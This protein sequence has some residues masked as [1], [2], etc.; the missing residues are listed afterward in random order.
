MEN[1]KTL[2]IS[3]TLMLTKHI[4]NKL[5]ECVITHFKTKHKIGEAYND[6]QLFG[7]GNFKEEKPNLKS[8]F[9]QILKGYVNGKYLYNKSREANSGKPIIKI[10]R[11]Y[12][13]VFFNYLGYKNIS[14]FLADINISSSQKE[15]QLDLVQQ[16]G[17]LEDF[18]YVCYYFGEDNQMNKGSVIIYNQWKTIE[19]KYLYE[20]E[21]GN[22]STYTFFGNITH[23]EDF[24]FFDTKYYLGNKKNEGAKFIFFI[25]KSSP[26]ERNY[27]AGTYSGF[28]KYHRAIAGKMILKKYATKLEVEEEVSNRVFDSIICLE[29]TK[30]RIIVESNI[31]KNPIMFSK[32]S[33]YAKVLSNTSG[34]YNAHFFI[35]NEVYKLKLQIQKTHLNILSLDDS[36]VIENDTINIINKGQILNLDFALTGMFHLQKVSLYLK[37]YD[38]SSNGKKSEGNYNGVDVN[39]NLVMGKVIIESLTQKH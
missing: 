8:D 13:Y 21:A 26:N 11:E 30:K 37:A 25:G 9:E 12:K 20:Y 3:E 4:F 24:V 18:Y 15:L 33:P 32:K 39:N 36:V 29:L 2:Q 16:K 19:M 38:V 35:E 14:E 27:L 22:K 7:F 34:V 6:T 31:R 28:D 17:S 5:L 23:S 1:E 10:S